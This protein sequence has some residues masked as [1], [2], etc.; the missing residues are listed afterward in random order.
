MKPDAHH[1]KKFS[2]RLFGIA[3]LLLAAA[4]PFSS[5]FARDT[6]ADRAI[7]KEAVVCEVVRDFR[8]VNPAITFSIEKGSITCFTRFA[9]ISSE[10]FI[11]HRWYRK[12]KLVTEQQLVVKPPQWSTYSSIQLREFDKGPWR[13]DIV[14]PNNRVLTILRFSVTE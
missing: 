11:S 4:G 13:V 6:Q 14:D 7:L 3:V 1:G 10:T 12:D 9:F 5:G 8:P 2:L